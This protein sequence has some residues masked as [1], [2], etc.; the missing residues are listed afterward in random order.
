MGAYDIYLSPPHLD[1]GELELVTQAIR[2]NWVAP[3]GPDLTALEAEM[4][5]YLGGGVHCVALASGTA[6]VHL[7][8]HIIGVGPGDEVACSDLTFIGSASP[9]MYQGADPVFVDAEPGTWNLDL[10]LLEEWLD[11]RVRRKRPPRAVVAVHLYGQPVDMDRLHDMCAPLGVEVVEDAAEALG[12]QYRGRRC[13]ALAR[14]G[15]LS[16]NGNKIMTTSG[17]GMLVC[18]DEADARQARFL[19]TQARDPAPHYEH[20]T[21]GFNYRLSNICAAIGRGQLR[22]LPGRVEAKRSLFEGYR[23]RLGGLD[24]IEFMPEVEFGRGN[25]WLTCIRFQDR[26]GDGFARRER[27]RLALEAERIESRPVWKPMHMQPVF[28]ECAV[29]GGAA[30]R[31]LF[32]NGL[33][34]PSGTA[35]READLD[36]ICTIVRESAG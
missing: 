21:L 30:G 26:A 12:A 20:S 2:S 33:C 4:A 9:V 25:R 15:V 16:F 13:G 19:A 11:E 18:R 32:R 23:Q 31:D 8:L 6:A 1:G 36:R 14:F 22:S 7:A 17:G 3:V 24:G 34:L 5:E 27:V 29:L 10:D 35:L 28:T